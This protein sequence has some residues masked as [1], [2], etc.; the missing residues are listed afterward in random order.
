V[1]LNTSEEIKYPLMA[2]ASLQY[3][4]ALLTYEENE[5]YIVYQYTVY[6]YMHC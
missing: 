3:R 1:T 4:Y 2:D 5:I 6:Q